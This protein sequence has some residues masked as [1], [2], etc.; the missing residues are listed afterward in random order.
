MDVSSSAVLTAP[1][2][3]RATLRAS[4]A[5][6][7]A[8][9]AGGW[10]RAAAQVATPGPAGDGAGIVFIQGFGSGSLFRTQGSGPDLPPYTLYLWE[11]NDP[12]AFVSATGEGSVGVLG[13]DRFLAALA[14]GDNPARAVFVAQPADEPDGGDAGEFVRVLDLVLAERGSDP[15]S[16]TYQGDIVPAAEGGDATP[17]SEP[18]DVQNV[19]RGYLFVTGVSDVRLDAEADVDV[20]LP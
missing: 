4:G 19:E 18:V 10:G 2:S 8:I 13:V 11:A 20:R 3:R 12:I 15:G 14:A 17:A 5:L 9:M 7:T 6:A 1:R 16:M